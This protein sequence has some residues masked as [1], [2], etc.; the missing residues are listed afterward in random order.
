LLKESGS[1]IGGTLGPA[2]RGAPPATVS[3]V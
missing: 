1:E 3:V 2:A